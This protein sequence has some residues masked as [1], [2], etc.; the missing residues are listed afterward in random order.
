MKERLAET[1]RN[2]VRLTFGVRPSCPWVP[3]GLV[4]RRMFRRIS[5]G[6]AFE[7][8]PLRMTG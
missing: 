8:I 5:Y 2:M 7:Q 4:A 3:A 6:P 1:M